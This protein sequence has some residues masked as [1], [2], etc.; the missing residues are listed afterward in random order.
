MQLAYDLQCISLWWC[1]NV[2]GSKPGVLSGRWEDDVYRLFST[3]R[4]YHTIHS[5]FVIVSCSFLGFHDCLSLESRVTRIINF[6]MERS[7]MRCPEPL[8]TN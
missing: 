1:L 4:V 6:F 8:A 2:R 3:G 5:G 7:C